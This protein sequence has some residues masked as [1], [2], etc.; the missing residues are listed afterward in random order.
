VVLVWRSRDPHRQRSTGQSRVTHSYKSRGRRP[1]LLFIHQH[2]HAPAPAVHI[3]MQNRLS[4]IL[5]NVP[6]CPLV[7][8]MEIQC[9]KVIIFRVQKVQISTFRI[10]THEVEA[11]Q[12]FVTHR[13][14]TR[15]TALMRMGSTGFSSSAWEADERLKFV[16]Q[17]RILI[18]RPI[19][20]N[21]P[22][23]RAS[24]ATWHILPTHIIASP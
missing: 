18:V 9:I 16:F 24:R 22:S 15:A 20:C 19:S 21:S 7:V 13:S 1:S 10:L 23:D 12:A 3:R 8:L 11:G 17:S 2:P 6:T 5:H 14:S 4:S